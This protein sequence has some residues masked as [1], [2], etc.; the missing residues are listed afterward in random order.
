MGKT[1]KFSNP[2]V[3]E[4]V[5]GV[6]FPE[7]EGFRAVHF[8]LYWETLRDRYPELS[9]QP[10]LEPVRE[11]FPRAPMIPGPRFE[12][13]QR[14]PPGRV[15][16]TATSGSELIQL[17]PDRFLFNWRRRSPDEPYPSY[18][19]NSKTF[20]DEFDRF[21]QFCRAETYGA[22]SRDLRSDVSESYR[23]STG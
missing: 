12:L 1:P 20:F 10:R 4:T 6:Q 11:R 2:P 15:W 21:R 17:Q 22:H 8:G 7:I 3:V 5:L 13:L 9:D 19:T 14:M 16:Y 18:E 23:S